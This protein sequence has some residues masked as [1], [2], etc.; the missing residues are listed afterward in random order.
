MHCFYAAHVVT[1]KVGNYELSTEPFYTPF[2]LELP[3]EFHNCFGLSRT[4]PSCA[5][6]TLVCYY[7][8]PLH[9]EFTTEEDTHTG[10]LMEN[11]E[12]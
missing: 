10:A 11:S 9:F 8:F 1:R 12:K 4:S 3:L 2:F 6:S 7:Q 5:T